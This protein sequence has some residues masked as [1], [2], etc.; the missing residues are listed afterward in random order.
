MKIRLFFTFVLA[1]TIIAK[2]SFAAV[3]VV[4]IVGN[5]CEKFSSN[6]SKSSVRVRVADKASYKAVSQISYL[7]EIKAKVLDHDFNVMVYNLVDNYV[8]DL[9]IK[10][11]SQNA[12]E[13][14]VEVTGVIPSEDIVNVIANY[15]SNTPAPEYDFKLAND[16]KE[17]QIEDIVPTVEQTVKVEEKKPE[18]EV[19]YQGEAKE[20]ILSQD[21]NIL[22][23]E[24]GVVA[25]EDTKALV[26]VAPVEFFN[27]THSSKPAKVIK[28]MFN[29]QELYKMV[30]TPDN[31][32]YILISKVMKAKIDALNSKTKRLQMVISIELKSKDSSISTTE[33]QNRFVLFE[34]GQSEQ[35]VAQNL[36]QKLL[37]NA[38]EKL[39]SKVEQSESKRQ[40]MVMPQIITPTPIM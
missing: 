4:K 9:A 15:S 32:D 30:E 29:N 12:E 25:V 20:I 5:A 39:Y 10:T 2:T 19:V 3:S 40:D 37:K 31:A 34:D 38:G 21:N 6:L 27:N 24:Q 33:H 35:K 8:Q 13:L 1:L 23:K 11:V 17:E 26:Y 14:C 18:A 16:I 36:L 22:D 7:S 28:D